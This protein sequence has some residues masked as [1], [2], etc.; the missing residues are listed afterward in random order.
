MDLLCEAAMT[1]RRRPFRMDILS[2]GSP[3]T[4]VVYP[5]LFI[6]LYYPFGS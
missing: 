4:S 3:G 6:H 2:E 5:S 1:F